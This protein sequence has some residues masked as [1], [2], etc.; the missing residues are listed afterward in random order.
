MSNRRETRF[1]LHLPSGVILDVD[2]DPPEFPNTVEDIPDSE[3]RELGSIDPITWRREIDWT[4]AS[5]WRPLSEV[6]R[7]P[8]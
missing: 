5:A 8:F 7:N 3:W 6:W 1:T 4:R 2:G